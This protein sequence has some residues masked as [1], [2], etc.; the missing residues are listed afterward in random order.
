MCRWVENEKDLQ[1]Y[2]GRVQAEE[3]KE[4]K[5]REETKGEEK[6]DK[7]YGKKKGVKENDDKEEKKWLEQSRNSKTIK[8]KR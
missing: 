1:V 4:E 6:N 8:G 2:E 7:E 5:E 3:G